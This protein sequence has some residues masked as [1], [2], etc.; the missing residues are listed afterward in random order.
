MT[1]DKA[2]VII[3]VPLL[4]IHHDVMAYDESFG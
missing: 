2:D 3:S 4:H 1:K